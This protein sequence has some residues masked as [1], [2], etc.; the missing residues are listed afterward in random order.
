MGSGG[1]GVGVGVG[2]EAV[3]R[4]VLDMD[5]RLAVGDEVNDPRN[6]F[7]NQEDRT[8]RKR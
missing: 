7:S 8:E 3:G 5:M 1:L 4:G 6:C 2:D